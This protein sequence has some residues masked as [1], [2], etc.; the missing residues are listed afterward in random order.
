MSISLPLAS[1]QADS[2]A[3]HSRTIAQ[4]FDAL[5]KALS[6]EDSRPKASR[7]QQVLRDNLAAHLTVLLSI[8]TGSYR[9][10]TQIPPLDDIDVLLVLDPQTYREYYYDTPHH[11]ASLLRLLRKALQ[12]AYP[13]SEVALP[14]D[15][16]I[17]IDFTGTGI[18]FDVTPAFQLSEDVFVIPDSRLGRWIQTNPKEHQ[19]QV[20]HANQNVCG[21]WLVPLVKLLK[22]W[23]Q[24]HGNLLTGFHLEV[25]AL[26]ALRHAPSDARAGVAFL[27]D[28]L[29]T[30]VRY[31]TP[32]PWPQGMDVDEYLDAST[33]ERAAERLREAAGL[34]RAAVQ[35]EQSGDLEAAHWAW[36]ELFGLRYPERGRKAAPARPLPPFAAADRIARG[37]AISAT[38]AGLVLPSAGYSYAPSGTSHGGDWEPDVG[39]AESTDD[40]AVQVEMQIEE[41]LGQFTALR[42]VLPE[43]AVL[44]PTLWPVYGQD[45]ATLRAVLVGEQR[46]NLGGR[47]RVLVAVP[48]GAPTTESRVY[49]LEYRP[50]Y[51]HDGT[52]RYRV[53]RP[54]RHLWRRGSLCTHAQHDRWD[55]RLITLMIWAAEWLFRQDHWQR[56]GVWVGAEIGRRGERRVNALHGG[57]YRRRPR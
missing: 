32:D 33:R 4:A 52:G 23:N 24:G 39:D 6:I 2:S 22:L 21:Q 26:R 30:D 34:A 47:H 8:L 20:A 41:V 5:F 31:R 40:G 28:A 13:N 10:G 48:A 11:T 16:C 57:A 42:R 44:D 17:R 19:R 3:S 7:Q 18:G 45:S 12:D 46:T 9:R 25:M 53:A 36:S 15:R 14:H 37:G 43:E 35:A 55:G 51:T 54:V 50:R 56:H 27:F 49:A 29:A 1:N 38:S